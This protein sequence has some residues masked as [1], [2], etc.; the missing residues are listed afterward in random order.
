MALNGPVSRVGKELI[1]LLEIKSKLYSIYINIVNKL[2]VR[3][4]SIILRLL[5]I[6]DTTI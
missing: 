2:I 3:I 6:I 4:T 5:L 1:R